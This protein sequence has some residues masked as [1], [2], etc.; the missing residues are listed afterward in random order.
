LREGINVFSHGGRGSVFGPYL[1]KYNQ[2][3]KEPAGENLA[4][5]RAGAV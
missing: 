4:T 3:L 1:N 5:D 2:I